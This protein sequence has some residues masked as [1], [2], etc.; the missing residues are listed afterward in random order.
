MDVAILTPLF[1]LL[2]TLVGGLITFA[3]N[4]QQF[5][6]QIAALHQQY[7]TECMAEETAR[8]FLNHE[9]YTDRSFEHLQKSLGGF[10]E[11]EL[12]KILVRAGA[13]RTYRE[14]DSEWWY[15]LSRMPER[16]EKMQAR[17]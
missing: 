6:H 10:E 7:K 14:D 16:I 4:R 1:T 11:D 8:H 15:L 12:R 9:G 13:V 3:V 17:S 2:G 5:K